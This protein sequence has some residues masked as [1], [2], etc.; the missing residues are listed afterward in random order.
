MRTR[1]DLTGRVFGRW[2]VVAR[3]STKTYHNHRWQCHCICGKKRNVSV[4]ALLA[5]ESKSC[6]CL[7][8]ELR[9][10]PRGIRVTHKRTQAGKR[11]PEL[12]VWGG[13]KTRCYN[14]KARCF[15][16]YGGRGI[17]ICDRW[18]NFDN[19]LADVGMRPSA[20]HS[21][22][23]I[24]V[25]GNYE[26]GNVRWATKKEQEA[27]KRPR[28]LMDLVGN[29]YKDFTVISEG[30][31]AKPRGKRRWGARQWVCRCICGVT[32]LLPHYDLRRNR[33]SSCACSTAKEAA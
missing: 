10:N 8:L 28:V 30:E 4:S 7:A 27:N 29:Q 32:K 2:T 11:S 9:K 24:D 33:V 17:I 3:A 18:H 31:R 15:S 26:P 16:A 25:N 22:D 14:T 5:G 23:R 6:G 19:F 12:C 20:E 13:M 1:I 21:I